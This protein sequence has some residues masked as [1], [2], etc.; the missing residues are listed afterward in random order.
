[1]FGGSTANGVSNKLYMI[2]FTK[3]SV[4]SLIIRLCIILSHINY[5]TLIVLFSQDIKE[6]P[7]PGG[8]VQWPAR[9]DAHSSVLVNNS[10][11]PHLLVMGGRPTRDY[12]LLDVY[13]RKWM[14]LVSIT[15]IIPNHENLHGTLT[16]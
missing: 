15:M 1:M 7:K 6:I 13:K 9:R 11:G 3:T 4:V 5:Y 16:F 14:K 2:S 8:L 12:W 10:L